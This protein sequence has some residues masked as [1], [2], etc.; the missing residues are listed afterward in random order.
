MNLVSDL[1][2]M[3]IPYVSFVFKK[4]DIDK[5]ANCT[6]TYHRL[7]TD[8]CPMSALRIIGMVGLQR[9]PRLY[10]GDSRHAPLYD[11]D[12]TIELD[13]RKYISDCLEERVTDKEIKKIRRMLSNGDDTK[14]CRYILNL[15]LRRIL[16]TGV[17]I[18]EIDSLIAN[19]IPLENI[20]TQMMSKYNLQDKLPQVELNTL[21]SNTIDKFVPLVITSKTIRYTKRSPSMFA[22]RVCCREMA[23]EKVR[24]WDISPEPC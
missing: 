6:D 16:K 18:T 4:S 7:V 3:H 13:K 19:K 12:N 1:D 9:N 24:I 20:T 2:I 10:F 5:I 15:F 14:L 8:K 11:D 21:I 17:E 23:T 22:Y